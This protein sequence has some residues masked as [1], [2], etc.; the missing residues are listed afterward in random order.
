[1]VQDMEQS[2]DVLLVSAT[3]RHLNILDNHIPNDGAATFAGQQ[4]LSKCCCG[5]LGQMFVLG[6]G[7]HLLLCQ[8]AQADTIFQRDHDL[9]GG[10]AA[11]GRFVPSLLLPTYYA[12]R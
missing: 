12:K 7:K 1:M 8:A 3:L 10:A 11:F 9:C 4:V 2:Q 5:D 6:N